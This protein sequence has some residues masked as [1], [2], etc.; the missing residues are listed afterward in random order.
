MA[1]ACPF[2][3]RAFSAWRI[4][5]FLQNCEVTGSCPRLRRP[6]I[7]RTRRFGGLAQETGGRTHGIAGGDRR[8]RGSRHRRIERPRT[9]LSGE[10][11]TAR[12]VPQKSDEFT[13]TRCLLIHHHNRLADAVESICRDYAD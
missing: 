11:F 4:R 7:H 1:P 5:R 9:D 13:C 12:V 6:S 8:R 3:G 2:P 10:E